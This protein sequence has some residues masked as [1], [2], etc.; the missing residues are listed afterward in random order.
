MKLNRLCSNC[1]NIIIYKT[2]SQLNDAIKKN[3][4]C[5]LCANRKNG[6]TKKYIG[7]LIKKCI[8]CNIDVE[9]S[10]SMHYKRAKS[11]RFYLCK[12]C[13]VR[14]SHTGKKISQK[15]K[16]LLRKRQLGI[17]WP[18]ERRKKLSETMKGKNNPMYGKIRHDYRIRWLSSLEKSGVTLRT[19]YNPKACKIIDEYGKKYGYNFQ[20]AE[21][22]GEYYIKELGYWTDG[23]DKEKNVVIE[24]YEPYHTRTE[25]QILKDD[26]RQKLIINHLKCKFIVIKEGDKI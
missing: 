4:I 19:F 24:Y 26:N 25:K 7:T 10:N 6:R 3:R 16:S 13:A 17:R 2:K 1:S 15:Q 11:D 18:L 21:N 12:S 22:G 8:L 23:Y 5:K 14:K 20:H 9:F